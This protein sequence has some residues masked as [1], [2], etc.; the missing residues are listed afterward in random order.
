MNVYPEPLPPLGVAQILPLLTIQA[1]GLVVVKVAVIDGVD[2]IVNT[3]G[4][5]VQPFASFINKV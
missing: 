2:V 4:G 3:C 5:F 1:E